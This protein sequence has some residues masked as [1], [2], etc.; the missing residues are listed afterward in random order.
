MA[1]RSANDVLATSMAGCPAG[2]SE[3][4]LSLVH[5]LHLQDQP[6][7][8]DS[9]VDEPGQRDNETYTRK[10]PVFQMPTHKQISTSIGTG[11]GARW[12]F[13]VHL[14]CKTHICCL[15]H[16][17]SRVM[18]HC[19]NTGLDVESRSKAICRMPC[20]HRPCQCNNYNEFRCSGE[21]L[22]ILA[23]SLSKTRCTLQVRASP[24]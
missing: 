9:R 15:D 11:E 14:S 20:L 4:T 24:D 7:T 10:G 8:Y 19:H 12:Y 6:C 16:K 1:N 21:L 2:P 13:D 18:Q 5:D 22:H 3:K 17:H 23:C